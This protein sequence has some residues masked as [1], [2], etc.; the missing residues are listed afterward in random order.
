[1]DTFVDSS[2]YYLRFL[3][4]RNEKEFCRQDLMERWLPVDVYIGGI[5]HAILHLLYARFVHKALYDIGAIPKHPEPFKQLI[6][7]GMVK[8]KTYRLKSNGKYLFPN[9]RAGYT[10][11][12]MN[13]N[14]DK[15]SKSKGN[16]VH[17][18]EVVEQFG[19]DCLRMAMFF[20]GPIEK[21]VYWDEALLK[22]IE[23]FLEKLSGLSGKI[24]EEIKKGNQALEQVNFSEYFTGLNKAENEGKKKFLLGA[25]DIIDSLESSLSRKERHLHVAVA[26]VMETIN[27][28]HENREEF[29]K[30]PVEAFFCL[31]LLLINAF[32]LAPFLT[33]ELWEGL[34]GLQSQVDKH[35]YFGDVSKLLKEQKIFSPKE[36]RALIKSAEEDA[37]M[38]IFV[39][40]KAKGVLKVP[41]KV[42]NDEKE[43]Q[44]FIIEQD[45]KGLEKGIQ[46]LIRPKGK[47]LINL[48]AK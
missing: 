14:Y 38:D 11:E 29:S 34:Q 15:M 43:L 12:E 44:K 2:W 19:S 4:P 31:R 18:I 24:S 22:T 9:E 27:Y 17:P 3:D 8:G 25:L 45:V 10:P 35:A 42:L 39:N 33:S 48:I 32:P 1:M 47:N 46:K 23:G 13:V 28:L 6:T 41:L 36:I 20:Y 21:D 30:Y 40:G 7:Q 37:V 26:R 16:G 5:E